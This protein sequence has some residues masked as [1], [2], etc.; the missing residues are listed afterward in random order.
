[1][2]RSLHSALRRTAVAF[3]LRRCYPWN[4]HA[5]TARNPSKPGC[6]RVDGGSQDS[7][8]GY[9]ITSKEMGRNCGAAQGVSATIP[10]AGPPNACTATAGHRVT[11]GWVHKRRFELT[12]PVLLFNTCEA[13]GTVLLWRRQNPLLDVGRRSSL[14][15]LQRPARLC[16]FAQSRPSWGCTWEGRCSIAQASVCNGGMGGR[17]ARAGCRHE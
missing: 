12:F 2:Q 13:P 7:Q 17:L 11:R 10:S 4:W 1:M 16:F 9:L 6:T 5:D 15:G 14:T 3:S 8:P